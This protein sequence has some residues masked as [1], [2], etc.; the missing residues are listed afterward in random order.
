VIGCGHDDIRFFHEQSSRM[1]GIGNGHFSHLQ[2]SQE[3]KTCGMK[4]IE[5][6]GM[7]RE[8]S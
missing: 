2:L 8:T 3:L 4:R 1:V 6:Q 5:L 7:K